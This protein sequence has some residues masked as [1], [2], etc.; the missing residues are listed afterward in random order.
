M[1]QK[2]SKM[3]RISAISKS[4]LDHLS[5]SHSIKK[6]LVNDWAEISFDFDSSIKKI[7]R[8]TNA[9]QK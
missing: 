6:N 8:L 7:K 9:R 4:V 5:I 3:F 1:M 2:L